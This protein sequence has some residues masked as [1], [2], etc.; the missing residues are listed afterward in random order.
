MCVRAMWNVFWSWQVK[1]IFV[2]RSLFRW[3]VNWTLVD[4]G[5]CWCNSKSTQS[6][7]AGQS[8]ALSPIERAR[9]RIPLCYCFEVWAFSFSSR[10]LSRLSCINEYLAKDNGGNVS[11]LVVARNCCMTRML[12]REA[13]LVSEW[14]ARS[15]REGKKCKALWAVPWTGYCAI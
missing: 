12:P 2:N 8:L 11:D 6:I 15:V 13:E 1:A 5:V 4:T 3:S 9:V 14:T 10:S 7:L